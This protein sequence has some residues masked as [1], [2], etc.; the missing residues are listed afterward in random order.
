[1]INYSWDIKEI[2][3]APF[4]EGLENV[5]KS[6][7]YCVTATDSSDNLFTVIYGSVALAPVANPE[8]FIMY[9][10]L[11]KET[12]IGWLQNILDM[13]ELESRANIEINIQRNPPIITKP[14]PWSSTN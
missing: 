3:V 8:Q 9:E 5:V 11:Q 7:G 14:L 10:S 4:E 2:Q 6:V 1:M 13:T 12:V